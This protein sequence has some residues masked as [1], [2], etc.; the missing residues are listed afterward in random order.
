VALCALLL[1]A[2]LT[3]H[4]HHYQALTADRFYQTQAAITHQRLKRNEN[5]TPY[6]V[7]RLH[8]AKLGT[9]Y[10]TT[11]E[12]LRDITYREVTLT[13]IIDGMGFYDFLRGFYA[14]SFRISLLPDQRPGLYEQLLKGITD[15]HT[16]SWGAALFGALTLA[17][18][19][20]PDL[21]EAITRFGVAHLVALSGFHLGI[22]TLLIAALL[23][24]LYRFFH[25]R[26]FPWRNRFFDLGA[27]TFGVL[28][29]YLLLTHSPPSLLRAFAMFAFGLFLLSRHIRLLS[30]I[31]LLAVGLF[32]I[33]LFPGLL[34]SI[35]FGLSVAGVFYIFLYLRDFDHSIG[36]KNGLLLG[37]YV[38]VAMLPV[39]HFFFPLTSA[40]Q[41]LSPVLSLLFIPF[42]PIAIALHLLDLGHLAA[43]PVLA[44]LNI[45][46]PSWEVSTPPWFFTLYLG[47]S[48]LAAWRLVFHRLLLG[49]MMLWALWQYG[50]LSLFGG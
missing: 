10:T 24:P 47:L 22:L 2:N 41:W 19:I 4:Y 14:P 45:T 42:Y 12:K 39:V 36:W 21:R 46:L 33:A 8:N 23:N 1:A 40:T 30:F 6:Y 3:W 43:K 29:S 17:S 37:L 34:F 18:P 25:R 49:L 28:L 44:L 32:L 48:L 15:Q 50:V 35:G 27:I 38:F 16:S 5:G 11:Y 7:L 26:F 20:E 9:F 13:L 31:N